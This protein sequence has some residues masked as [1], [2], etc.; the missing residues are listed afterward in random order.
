MANTLPVSLPFAGVGPFQPLPTGT[1]DGTPLPGARP[2]DA[3]GVQIRAKAGD[4]Y[5]Y[6]LLPNTQAA[7]TAPP[8]ATSGP[9]SGPDREDIFFPPNL[10]I[11]FVVGTGTPTFRWM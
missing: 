1:A 7:P 11:Y 4:T 6:F 8:A 2:N 9:V 5:E 10:T 3:Q